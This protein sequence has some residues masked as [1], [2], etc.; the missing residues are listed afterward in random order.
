M[1]FIGALERA[2]RD[3]D[4]DSIRALGHRQ[5]TYSDGQNGAGGAKPMNA[6]QLAKQQADAMARQ[7]RVNN[8]HA[9]AQAMVG[10]ASPSANDRKTPSRPTRQPVKQTNVIAD[11]LGL[12]AMFTD[13]RKGQFEKDKA[14]G[15]N[16]SVAKINQ[17]KKFDAEAADEHSWGDVPLCAGPEDLLQEHGLGQGIMWYYKFMH[18]IIGYN[19]VL[20]LIA[21]ISFIPHI[22]TGPNY[23]GGQGTRF[24]GAFYLSTYTEKSYAP[25]VLS[26][27]L[28][29][30]LTFS[31]G[32][33]YRYYV[34]RWYAKQREARDAAAAG[35]QN[36]NWIE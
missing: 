18:F 26:V 35:D 12:T 15:K 17:E 8:A 4:A 22:V 20:L 32:P 13:F 1:F 33:T 36:V 23:D 6:D 21:L 27:T 31:L 5:D 34:K 10:T 9:T 28:M 2:V 24:P 29:L 11:A 3:P 19:F 7:Q 14:E 16:A 30:I 25:F